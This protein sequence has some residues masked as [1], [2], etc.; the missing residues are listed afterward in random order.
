MKEKRKAVKKSGTIPAEEVFDIVTATVAES[1]PFCVEL[2]TLDIFRT[3]VEG[4]RDIIA[5]G[6]TPGVSWE[7]PFVEFR[8]RERPLAEETM[9]A[10]DGIRLTSAEARKLSKTLLDDLPDLIEGWALDRMTNRVV[11]VEDLGGSREV[12]L[13]E[14]LEAD[15]AGMTEEDG[16]SAVEGLAAGMEI[17]LPITGTVDTPNG[18]QPWKAGLVFAIRPLFVDVRNHVAFFPVQVGLEFEE[19]SPAGW[20]DEQRETLWT[21]L[22]DAID[23]MAL[24]YLPT[25]GTPPPA[26]LKPDRALP[27]RSEYFKAPGRLFD[28]PRH[29]VRQDDLFQVGEWYQQASFNRTVAMALAALTKTGTRE[30]ILGWQSR[31]VGDITDLIFALSESD[32]PAHGDHRTAVIKG[33]EAL[34]AIPVPLVRID[35]KQVG[36]RWV[37]EY[38]YRVASLIQSYGAVFEDRKTGKVVR[39]DDP[40]RKKELVKAKEDR[41]KKTRALVAVNAA[42][43]LLKTFPADKFKLTGFEWR[44]NTDIAEDFICPLVALDPKSNPRLSPKGKR[45]IEGSRFVNLNKRYFAVMKSLRAGGSEYGQRLLDMI[46][47]EKTHIAGRGSGIVRIEIEAAKV[48]KHLGLWDRFEGHPKQVLEERIAPAVEAL[49]AEG[50]MLP[51]SWTTP[52]TDPNPD[53]RK[54]SFY[55]WK[56]AE[57]WTTVALVTED[58]AE[59][60]EA[61]L[62]EQAKDAEAAPVTIAPKVEA[63]PEAEQPTLPGLE[64]PAG[65]PIPTGS[66][67]KAARVAAGLDLRTF[68]K[69]IDGPSFKTWSLYE[70]GASNRIRTTPEVWQ[71]VR[72]FIAKGGS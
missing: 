17:P 42:D 14:N 48:I 67:V 12:V 6:N 13:P 18:P 40:V 72:E 38:K 19:G 59:D 1:V 4:L 31:A 11:I 58:Q 41:R 32:A 39:T 2:G 28:T 3:V 45:H 22:L 8:F 24:E 27:I 30:E 69:Q 21:A 60:I 5:K 26:H 20:S 57:L 35:W 33:L 68:A 44:W 55:R 71:R 53:R 52:Q 70:S 66:E 23:S 43:A 51:G 54:G 63:A 37:K 65:P 7:N 15:L 47:S 34:R 61:E 49:I 25:Q 36:K 50:V 62:V 16:L 64:A 10:E 56:V 9:T 29:A 46:V